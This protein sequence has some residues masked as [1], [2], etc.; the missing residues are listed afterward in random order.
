MPGKQLGMREGKGRTCAQSRAWRVA[1]RRRFSD[2]CSTPTFDL[3]VWASR[4][5]SLLLLFKWVIVLGI[6]FSG[7]AA[8]PSITDI[9]LRAAKIGSTMKR[10][11]G[12]N[13]G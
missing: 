10:G 11:L 5:P 1:R 13:V 9:P 12:A 4:V 8:G 2:A 6:R 7:E 3:Y